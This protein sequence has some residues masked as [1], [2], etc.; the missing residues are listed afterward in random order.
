M[1]PPV[2]G[3]GIDNHSKH[4]IECGQVERSSRFSGIK[5]IATREFLLRGDSLKSTISFKGMYPSTIAAQKSSTDIILSTE[6]RYL[7]HSK[8][9]ALD[10]KFQHEP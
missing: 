9:F 8:E 5:L 2:F 3:I 7:L 6:D 4:L 1:T 10:M